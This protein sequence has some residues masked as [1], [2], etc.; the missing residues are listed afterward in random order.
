MRLFNGNSTNWLLAAAAPLC[1]LLA[2]ATGY[3]TLGAVGAASALCL[4][5]LRQPQWPWRSARRDDAPAVEIK[6]PISSAD[7][8]DREVAGGTLLEQMVASGRVALLLR[9]QIASSLSPDDLAAA[10]ACLDQEMAIVPQGP[11]AVRARCYDVLD[12]EQ[13][14]RIERLIQVEGFFLDRHPV[15]NREYR[16][17]VSEGGYEQ[18]ALWDETIW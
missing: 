1:L 15:T 6:E 7:D 4:F 5:A 18:M 10:Q 3:W 13:A 12:E 9:P 8:D 17:F 16:R 14:Q 11:V 2:W